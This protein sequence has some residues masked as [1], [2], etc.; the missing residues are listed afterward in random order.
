MNQLFFQGNP[1]RFERPALHINLG[2]SVK[3]KIAKRILSVFIK[4]RVGT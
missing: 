3:K 4:Y 1:L 2:R